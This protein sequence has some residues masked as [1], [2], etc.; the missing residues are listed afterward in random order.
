MSYDRQLSNEILQKLIE[1][2]ASEEDIKE[3]KYYFGSRKLRDWTI[4]EINDI[5][6]IDNKTLSATVLKEVMDSI[7]TQNK[8]D[9]K[10]KPEQYDALIEGGLSQKKIRKI[11]L[12]LNEHK[13]GLTDYVDL[14][15][16]DLMPGPLFFHNMEKYGYLL[17]LDSKNA[18][19]L[20]KMKFRANIAIP[21]I[22]KFG[23]YFLKS[24]QIFEDR[25]EL[26]AYSKRKAELEKEGIFGAI[27]ESDL[28]YEKDPGIVLPDEPVIWTM[29]HRFKDDVLASIL[30]MPRPFSL[31]VGSVPQF[32]N[33]FDGV[34]AYTI[35]SIVLNRKSRESKRASQGKAETVLK[36]GLDLM[37][38]P[39]GIWNK[40]PHE[41]LVHLWR[42]VY[43]LAK[44]TNSK[45]VPI[46]HYIKDPT[47]RSPKKNNPIHT[48]VDNPI[49]IT[50]MPEKE[51]L[52]YFRDILAT[53]Y[54]IMMEK[55]GQ[56]TR[57]EILNGYD[58]MVDAYEEIMNARMSTV[59]RYDSEFEKRGTY[60]PKEIVNPEDVFEPIASIN[61]TKENILPQRYAKE[62]VLTRKKEN[63]QRRF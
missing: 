12:L 61:P 54:Y 2:G 31:Y 43:R 50:Y 16:D 57:K 44:K 6:A 36:A 29:N 39:E 35:G 60:H 13:E 63:F 46:V 17:D 42:G 4:E 51:A 14:V 1:T 7:R 11:E 18:S 20:E 38:S 5:L 58:N 62:L 26:L 24:P 56:S 48:V 9:G 25:N 37:I 30:S 49:D 10:L 55:Y 59:D 15:G 32:Y 53:W 41:L 27:D 3:I 34:L 33:T 23:K 28:K 19:S 40:T 8:F 21:L 45:L 47:Q 52:E 22:H